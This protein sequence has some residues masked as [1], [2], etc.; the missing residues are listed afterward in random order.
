MPTELVLA[1]RK[2]IGECV[3]LLK[4]LIRQN[5]GAINVSE[6]RR[7]GFSEALLGQLMEHP[8]LYLE[9]SMLKTTL[10]KDERAGVKVN[11]ML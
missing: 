5:G 10:T 2:A 9:A 6:I 11:I 8:D 7:H 4:E 3:G 1:H